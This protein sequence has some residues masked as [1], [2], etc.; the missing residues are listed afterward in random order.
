MQMEKGILVDGHGYVLALLQWDASK[1]RP[2]IRQ[3]AKNRAQMKRLLP[4]DVYEPGCENA[5][6]NFKEK[7]WVYPQTT[8]TLVAAD[9]T[10]RGERKAFRH[11]LPIPAPGTQWVK[12]DGAPRWRGRKP[13]WDGEKFV[14]P[15]VVEI[16]D[17]E[18]NVVNRVLENPREDTPNVVAP[19]GM[20]KRY[21]NVAAERGRGAG[22][23]KGDQAKAGNAKADRGT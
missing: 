8:W 17:K 21:A 14:E 6:W 16:T 20:K 7:K 18:G 9:G 15:H 10:V 5:R 11:Q 1:P 22:R 19:K 13:V 4:G 23:G 2:R 3:K 12:T